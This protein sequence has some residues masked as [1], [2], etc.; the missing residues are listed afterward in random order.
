MKNGD[1]DVAIDY[2][3]TVYGNYLGYSEIKSADEIYTIAAEELNKKYNLRM[4]IPLGFN[5]TYTLS[6]HPDIAKK[7]G[8]KTYSDLAKISKDLIFGGTFEILNRNDGIPSL[9]K[10][11]NMSFKE[12]KAVDGTLRYTAI[13][14]GEINITDAFSTD[15]LLLEY[16]LTVLE[17][18]KNF[19]PAYHAVPVIYGKTAEKYPDLLEKLLKL[20]GTINNETMRSLN[21]KVDVLKENPA[22]VAKSF[23]TEKK[24]IK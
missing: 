22:S 24:L 6:V 14:H 4:L 21:Y 12:E 5:N 3:G 9:K 7:Y 2:T 1:I 15:G 8:L 17:D 18:D 11:Y 16:E 23:L 10:V 13:Q 20:A 19:F